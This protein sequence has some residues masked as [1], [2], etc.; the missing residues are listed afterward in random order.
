VQ[1]RATG[2]C[3][4]VYVDLYWV[5]LEIIPDTNYIGYICGESYFIHMPQF[6][7]L[8]RTGPMLGHI[9]IFTRELSSSHFSVK[10]R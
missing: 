9:H 4:R 2:L 3:T 1:C 7:V 8:S 6:T 10:M 5:V